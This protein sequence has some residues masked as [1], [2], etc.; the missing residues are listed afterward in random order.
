[1]LFFRALRQARIRQREQNKHRA[2]FLRNRK[3]P[4][5][6]FFFQRNRINQ[7]PPR[8]NPQRRLNDIHMTRINTERTVHR[9]S[10]FINRFQHHFFLVDAV[11]PHIDIENLGAVFLLL[12]RHRAHE[13]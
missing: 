8:I 5:D 4:L 11:H 7:R 6:F 12:K 9:G 1:M 10:D 13:I 2:V 3:Q